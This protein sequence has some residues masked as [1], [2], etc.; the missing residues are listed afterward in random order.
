MDLGDF[1]EGENGRTQLLSFGR[2][3]DDERDFW[4]GSLNRARNEGGGSSEECRRHFNDET[5]IL[6]YF[7]KQFSKGV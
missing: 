3:E 2:E 4:F 5:L 7:S 6:K 1:K